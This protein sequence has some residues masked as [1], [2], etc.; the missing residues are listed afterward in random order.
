MRN[1]WIQAVQSATSIPEVGRLLIT[2]ETQV[3]YSAVTNDWRGYRDEWVRLWIIISDLVFNSG[4]RIG[5]SIA[6]LY[7]AGSFKSLLHTGLR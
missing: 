5:D 3:R 2:F 4:D 6:T 1:P 7:V